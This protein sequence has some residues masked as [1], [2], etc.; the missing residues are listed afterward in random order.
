MSVENNQSKYTYDGNGTTGPWSYPRY[1]IQDA[2]LLV[3]K[4]SAAGA[5]T[6]LTPSIDY[7]VFGAGVAAGGFVS[8][9][10]VVAI[11]EKIT[12]SGNVDYLQ[13]DE[14]PETGLMPAKTVERGLDR[15]TMM[16]QQ[17]K[18]I[19][20]RCLR[21]PISSTITEFLI[22]T[23]I[24]GRFLMYNAAGDGVENGPSG[25]DIA[26]ASA[27]ATAAAASAAEAAVSAA[28]AAANANFNANSTTGTNSY[29]INTGNTS[30]QAGHKY[31]IKFTLA[32]TNT[33]ITI[34]DT[35]TGAG[36]KNVRYY[37][38]GGTLQA[39]PLGTI[40]AGFVGFFLYDGTNFILLNPMTNLKGADVAA[41]ATTDFTQQHGDFVNLTGTTGIT[42]MTMQSGQQISLYY[43]GAGLS[44]TLGASLALNGLTSGTLVLQT[45]DVL[46]VRRDGTV[47][48]II[49][50]MRAS[51]RPAS[52]TGAESTIAS[53]STCDLGVLASKLVIITGTTDITSFGSSAS[54]LDPIYFI[55]FA[56][57][58]TLTHNGTSLII[59]GAANITTAVGDMAIMK[60]EGSGNWRVLNYVKASGLSIV[61]SG[62]TT[63]TKRTPSAVAEDT[64]TGIPS[65]AKKVSVH[66]LGLAKGGTEDFLVRVGPSGG[67]ASSGYICGGYRLGG[68][69]LAYTTGIAVNAS[70]SGL[71]GVHGRIDFTLIEQ[72]S[73]T[74]TYTGTLYGTA[75]ILAHVSG[76]VALSGAF[77]QIKITGLGGT[78]GNFSA[79]SWAVSYE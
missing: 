28:A 62:A 79:G 12:V 70:W 20:N 65:T 54:V 25:L 39:P 59:P 46:V 35:S 6:V 27:N 76:Q 72:S 60:Y 1:F 58:L 4:T 50:V 15:L 61:P 32:Q 33:N 66:F 19:T 36:A 23:P 26:N 18:E 53:A 5:D 21:L 34:T 51:G 77:E 63:M 9:T 71:G 16:V 24:A 69:A 2:D 75:V 48:R 74:W 10:A 37:G 45:G 7:N 11:G 41:A 22:D 8:T 56:G 78:P 57:A 40:S 67:V 30:L 49:T 13:P 14:Y 44:I 17:I 38:T 31:S 3:T 47:S 43:T 68:S 29:T 52:I 42:A 73:N 55:Q 64:Q